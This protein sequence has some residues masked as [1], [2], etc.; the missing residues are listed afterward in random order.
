MRKIALYF[1]IFIHLKMKINKY[2]Y[3]LRHI[4]K[5]NSSYVYIKEKSL[6][7]KFMSLKR[8]IKKE[9]VIKKEKN[10]S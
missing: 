7:G 3:Q 1:L 9:D 6:E 4:L 8:Y 5:R 10:F 2:F